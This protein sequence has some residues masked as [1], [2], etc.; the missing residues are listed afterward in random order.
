MT[1][2]A[3]KQVLVDVTWLQAH[4]EDPSVRIAEV[5]VDVYS[6]DEGHIPGAVGWNWSTQLCDTDRRDI[7]SKGD[8]E[9]LMR[10]AGITP[11]TTIV[12][13]G[14]NNNWF[15]A[16]AVWQLKIY[17]RQG[18]IVDGVGEPRQCADREELIP[19]MADSRSPE[20]QHR[21]EQVGPR[22]VGITSYRVG[23]LFAARIDNVDPGSIIGRGSGA[24]REEAESIAL[25]KALLSLDLEQAG[26]ALR[27]SVD[28]LDSDRPVPSSRRY[29]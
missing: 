29:R 2:S 9:A 4:R 12:L 16:W 14:D 11:A 7:L 17:G 5:D 6:Y 21:K 28:H 24:T 22:V 27:R 18:W 13:Y 20:T 8:L 25:G 1:A 10:A 19:D 15:A 23:S 26:Q 3:E